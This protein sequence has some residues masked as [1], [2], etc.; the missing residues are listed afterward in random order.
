MLNELLPKKL[1]RGKSAASL[2]GFCLLQLTIAGINTPYEA[3]ISSLAAATAALTVS[4]N[5][6]STAIAT[7]LSMFSSFYIS[8]SF[9]SSMVSQ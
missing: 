9:L 4:A 2:S 6:L 5:F 1:E 7:F 3:T 8:L